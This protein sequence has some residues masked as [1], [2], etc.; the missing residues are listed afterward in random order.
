MPGESADV[1]LV[2]DP[3]RGAHGGPGG[4]RRAAPLPGDDQA[5][6]PASDTRAEHVVAAAPGLASGQQPGVGIDQR[7]AAVH[8][9]H[10]L[11]A[12]R[13]VRRGSAPDP[14]RLRRG[15]VR[16]ELAAPH[17]LGAAALE[18]L[19]DHGAL[20]LCVNRELHRG[21]GPPGTELEIGRF[22]HLDRGDAGKARRCRRRPSLR[23]ST[24]PRGPSRCRPKRG[25]SPGCPLPASPSPAGS[26]PPPSSRRWGCR[27]GAGRRSAPGSGG[28]PS[29][30]P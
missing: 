27:P 28:R 21:A 19:D 16:L 12:L 8:P 2:E 20:G 30:P 1:E 23:R 26:G 18:D 9:Q 24:R 7:R 5:P 13:Q 10:V 29:A 22:A 17:R 15:T 6:V 25:A 4:R 14:E 3:L 11:E